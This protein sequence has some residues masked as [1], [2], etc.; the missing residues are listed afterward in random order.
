MT[1]VGVGLRA[2]HYEDFLARR[3]DGGWL[4]PN[5]IVIAE[6]AADDNTPST[7]G[8]TVLDDRVYGETRVTFL[9]APATRPP[10][11]AMS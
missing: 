1:K 5:A 2:A 4:A 8:F 3:R 11:G 10:R 6:C 7:D 9:R